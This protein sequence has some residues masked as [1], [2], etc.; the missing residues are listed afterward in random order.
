MYLNLSL[1]IQEPLQL[2]VFQNRGEK[3]IYRQE[4]GKLLILEPS[5]SIPR[6]TKGE[7]LKLP[8]MKLPLKQT[9]H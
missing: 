8:V 2:R 7:T 3:F 4:K 6:K 9:P 5:P 1:K